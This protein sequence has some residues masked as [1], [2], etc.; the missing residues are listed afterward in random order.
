MDETAKHATVGRVL[1]RDLLKLCER[2]DTLA[3]EPLRPGVEVHW[4]HRDGSGGRRAALLRYAPG[5]SVPEHLHAGGEYIIVLSGSQRD[6]SDTYPA[7]TVLFN[8]PGSRHSVTSDAGCVVLAL[9]EKPV[10]FIA[11]PA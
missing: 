3:W 11:P 5:A 10:Q 7:G 8:A 9:W 4:L 2:L 6:E 1:V